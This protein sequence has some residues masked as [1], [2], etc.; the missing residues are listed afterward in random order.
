MSA[1][2]FISYSAKDRA[3]VIGIVDKL[4]DA[5]V[6]VWIDQVG[7]EA[8][9]MWSREI[10]SA[11]KQ[12]K[13]MLLVISPH[14]ASSENVVKELALGSE[15]K[16]PIIPI[17]IEPT[18]I[19]E[20]M[21]YQLAGIQRVQYFGGFARGAF[22]TTLRALSKRGVKVRIDA[23]NEGD[24][25]NLEDR[26]GLKSP[27][28][29]QGCR[30]R[31]FTILVTFAVIFVAAALI[32]YLFRSISGANQPPP[33]IS[34]GQT[35][36]EKGSV[37][38][39][40]FKNIGP[41]TSNSFIAE[42]MHEEINA[43]LSIV[44]SLIV[45][46]GSRFV[47]QTDN[48]KSVGKSLGVRSVLTGSVIQS[49]GQLRVIVKLVDATTEANLWAATFD[50]NEEDFF[51][52]QRDIAEN[53]AKG[54]SVTLSNNY[55]TQIR[56]RL[57]EN[58]GAYKLY[59]EGRLL[60]NSRKKTEMYQA[61][62]KYE[63]AVARDPEFALGY[64]GIA[65]CYNMIAAY[66]F[67]PPGIAYPKAKAALDKALLINR[68]ISKLHSSLGWYYWNFE[69][70]FD[71]AEKALLEAVKL[72]PSSPE[73]NRWYAQV[74]SIRFKPESIDE[75]ELAVKLEPSSAI[76]RFVQFRVL[77]SFGKLAEARIVA[78]KVIEIDQEYLMAL[79]GD[80]E[81]HCLSQRYEEAL[82]LVE[83]AIEATDDPLYLG[84]KG[85]ILGR[86]NRIDEA[87]SVRIMLE[88]IALKRN[89]RPQYMFMIDYAIGEH[90]KALKLLRESVDSKTLNVFLF[91]PRI[92]WD[93]LVGNPAFKTI[94]SDMGLPLKP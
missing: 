35:N 55:K 94:F 68:N 53:V 70:D 81:I 11:I 24:F 3:R 42:G 85:Y 59:L 31:W 48:V 75:I 16:K 10:V 25:V 47:D 58:L 27:E 40:P 18:E 4:T 66:G 1:E 44:P 22:E 69:Y 41:A 77:T 5:G 78:K 2:V 33:S 60:W 23:P 63:L 36:A 79:Y 72:N 51:K 39:V 9:S 64:I 8:S 29:R 34:A 26:G 50:G 57:T 43:I 14:S 71:S 92:Y 93:D 6:S 52:I 7:I 13:V 88:K 19:P 32:N 12:C 87:N 49:G 38:I 65:E 15:R 37:A 84:V 62:E 80:I 73:A 89:V 45:K 90:E 83:E 61:I 17:I 76:S 91:D 74:R 21:E 30:K 56:K 67:S 54:L 86:L 28:G 46:D 20:T 82:V